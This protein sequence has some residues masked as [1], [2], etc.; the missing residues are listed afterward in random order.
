MAVVSIEGTDL[1]VEIEG[2]DKLWAFKSRLTV[3][4]EHVRGAHADPNVMS[5]PKG[6][7]GPG[8][9]VPGVIVAGTY[10][11]DGQR[12]L[13]DVH[14]GRKAVVIEL[15]DE[16]YQRIVIGV[17]DPNA[18]VALVAAALTRL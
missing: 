12:I 6:W 7:R 13:W 9:N 5:E 11:Q 15:H 4:L 2:L 10:H 8:S 16:T 14:D 1:V 3:P 18:T 17:D